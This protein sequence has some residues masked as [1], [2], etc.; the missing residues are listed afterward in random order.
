MKQ[1]HENN[2]R[3]SIRYQQKFNG[4][5]VM[6]GELIVNTDDEGN[7]YSMNGEVSPDLSLD[8]QPTI[9]AKQAKA[10]ALQ[11]MTKWYQNNSDDF[12][13]TEPELWIFDESLLQPSTR[14]IELVW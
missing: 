7:L 2:G 11:S 8:T 10:S 9:D 1:K 5:P 6:A 14:P 4:V 3:S 13:T 12:T